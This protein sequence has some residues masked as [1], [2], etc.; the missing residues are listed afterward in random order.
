MRLILFGPPGAGKGTQAK[1]LC[2]KYNIPQVSTGDI[3]RQAV[4]DETPLGKEA[5]GYMLKGLLVPDEIIL[6]IVREKLLHAECMNGYILDGFPR[7]LVQGKALQESL[8]VKGEEIDC[9]LNLEV[10]SE[11]IV[12]RLS[13]RRVCG[14]CG[15]GYHILFQPPTKGNKCDNCGGELLQRKDDYEETIRE[16]LRQYQEQTSPLIEYYQTQGKLHSIDG[17][18][19]I[20]DIYSAIEAVLTGLGV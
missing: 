2:E 9:V 7:T 15:Q 16:R 4:K 1:M 8:R 13:G 20:K 17:S 14:D 11:Q 10:P 3:L 5:Q 18:G 19:D 12:D 6:G